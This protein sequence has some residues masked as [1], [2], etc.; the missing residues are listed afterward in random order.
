MERQT[1]ED[2][3]PVVISI[4][5]EKVN[6]PKFQNG[7]LINCVDEWSKITSDSWILRTITG[8][9]LELNAQPRRIIT[10]RGIKFSPEEICVPD[11]EKN[12]LEDMGAITRTKHC[13]G[14]FISNI[15]ITPKRDGYSV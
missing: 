12:K 13:K 7:N 15:L 4:T 11:A 6:M 1:S 10:P 9:R 8:Y 2:A 3:I 14:E 5:S